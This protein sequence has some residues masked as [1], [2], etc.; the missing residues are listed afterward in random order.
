MKIEACQI[1][2]SNPIFEA[3]CTE[4][5][6]VSSLF[7]YP[8]FMDTSFH[9]R[10]GQLKQYPKDR[11]KDVGEALLQYNKLVDNHPRA[12]ENIHRF[13]DEDALV[14]VGGQQAGILTGPLYS[15]YKAISI[16]QL[17]NKWSESLQRPVIPVFW[18]AGEDHDFAEV[19]H[20]YL[21][22]KDNSIERQ[23][24]PLEGEQRIPISYRRIEPKVLSEYV[25]HF[26]DSC[27]QTEF[28][29]SLKQAYLELAQASSS[30][31]EFFSKIMVRLL[32]EHGL[33]LIDSAYPPLRHVESPLFARI[34]K[35]NSQVQAAFRQGKMQVMELDYPC[36]IQTVE[37]NGHLFYIKEQERELL[38]HMEGKWSGKHGELKW[39]T[40]ALLRLLE[41]DPS[42]FS[43][44]VVTRPLM[45]EYLF[46]T[47]AFVAGPGEI[48]YW[49]MLKPLFQWLGSP[50]P[51][52]I[53]RF[54]GTIV[55]G[56]IQKLLRKYDL[57]C[58]QVLHGVEQYKDAWI[59]G[60]DDQQLL[61]QFTHLQEDLVRRY[62]TILAGLEQIHDG[63]KQLGEKN[64]Q[65]ILEQVQF[66]Q[67]RTLNEMEKQH[68]T[69]IQ[70]FQRMEYGLLPTGRYQERTYNIFQYINKYGE[71]WFKELMQC[72]LPADGCHYE[73]CLGGAT[74]SPA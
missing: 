70:H 59:K 49:A 7:A 56:T 35:E 39:D 36:Q 41:A 40:P 37:E 68:H 15:I 52:I 1:G 23:R 63:M 20:T 31:T 44:N 48:A 55:E 9:D 10:V 73:I 71:N 57:K 50:M 72:D 2:F 3:Y 30:L 11:R 19:N 13:I 54:S 8:P 62:D 53:P 17:A 24:L 67:Q 27:L 69:A 74:D 29:P 64:L 38:D 43:S 58:T 61:A 65:K 47:L 28:T 60:Q 66:L 4:Y 45:Q 12:L 51:P 14:I 21:L 25:N 6:R 33:V 22:N 26:F 32:G 5:S 34:I 42:R 18:I 16:V 46:P